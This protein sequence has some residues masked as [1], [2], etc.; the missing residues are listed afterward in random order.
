MGKNVHDDVLDAAL[1]YLSANGNRL[2]VLNAEP[3]GSSAYS[4]AQTDA[5]SSGYR[6]AEATIA[7]SAYTGP[8]NG[9]TSGRKITIA[10]QTSMSIDGITSAATDSATHVAI[11]KY[12]ASSASQAVLYTTTCT[13][14]TLTAGN[15]V[16]TPA[17]TVEL[18]DPS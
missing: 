12:H 3:T 13:A 11:V 15:K 6:L 16:N 10:A 2:V 18:R 17:W 9:V 14:Q 1:S 4:H 8:A 7:S 5:K